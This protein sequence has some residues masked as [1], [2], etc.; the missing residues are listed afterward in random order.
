MILLRF[1]LTFRRYD[2]GNI[3]FLVILLLLIRRS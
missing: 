3:T 1:A 2:G